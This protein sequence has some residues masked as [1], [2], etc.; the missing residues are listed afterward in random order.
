MTCAKQRVTAVIITVDQEVFVGR[1][2]CNSP[3]LTCPRIH[4]PSGVGYHF[5]QT[6]CHQ[7]GHAEVMAI[8]A[9]GDRAKGAT[10]VLT[11]HDH[12]CPDCQV[13]MDAAGIA[14][15]LIVGRTDERG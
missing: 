5:C 15:R 6:I 4:L 14:H 7:Q 12:F 10:L 2:D 8:G 11:G 9:A 3:Q 13:A 1:N